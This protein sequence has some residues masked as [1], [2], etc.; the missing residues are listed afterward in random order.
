MN[1]CLGYLKLCEIDASLRRALARSINEP[2]GE[3]RASFRQVVELW[4][5]CDSPFENESGRVLVKFMSK[6]RIPNN[7]VLEWITQKSATAVYHKCS[8]ILLQYIADA[9]GEPQ[10]KEE[11]E[12]DRMEGV[13]EGSSLVVPR[14]GEDQI[15][16]DE[17]NQGHGEVL[18]Q[19]EPEPHFSCLGEF[20]IA[21]I[22]S[23]QAQLY[24]IFIPIL[25][26][27]TEASSSAHSLKIL[28]AHIPAYCKREIKHEFKDV[29]INQIKLLGLIAVKAKA[30]LQDP[31][32]A[33]GQ[34]FV[35]YL[36]ER[37]SA[38]LKEKFSVYVK[39]EVFNLLSLIADFPVAQ[40]GGHMRQ[41]KFQH[42]RIFDRLEPSL[43]YVKKMHFPMKS[44][45]LRP[46]SNEAQNFLVI[47]EAFLNMAIITRN[48]K[49]LRHLYQIIREHKTTF[50]QILKNSIN[51]I[52]TQQINTLPTAD[53]VSCVSEFISEFRDRNMDH[54]V[55]D[56][57]RWAIAR[58]IIV[59]ILETCSQEKLLEV[60]LHWNSDFLA[61]LKGTEFSDFVDQPLGLFNLVR[62][63]TFVMVFYEIMYRRLP[64]QV[65]KETVHRRIYGPDCAQNELSKLLIE[66]AAHA[67][68]EHIRGF[69]TYCRDIASEEP[70]AEPKDDVNSPKAVQTMY[71]CSAYSLLSSVIVCTQ[72]NEVVFA[73]FLFNPRQGK[74]TESLWSLIIDT[75]QEY[76]FKVQT[77]FN[78]IE[79]RSI[80]QKLADSEAA[81][82]D[83]A[84]IRI[85]SMMNE[86]L[87]SS[88]MGANEGF[89]QNMV[90]ETQLD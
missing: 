39:K 16:A 15:I 56:N 61:V 27:L 45:E 48:L 2:S 79:L 3:G 90:F 41:G 42:Q 35:Q 87:T 18:K 59:R 29:A 84:G 13:L 65:I 46:Q 64:A 12:P 80:E 6:L 28:V 20:L 68:R 22:P 66:V 76:E 58:K 75:T 32:N 4:L 30:L 73:N 11:P 74:A 77:N 57:I 33:E 60:M 53:F 62:E 25:E 54:S 34:V 10:E 44:R 7:V 82:Q 55:S 72:T 71:C 26:K 43:N 38:F 31:D 14:A 89:N 63:K 40:G 23:H 81:S 78:H 21:K 52:V 24:S 47:V 86:Y 19:S 17:E 5:N 49:V 67:K 70:P 50:E 37:I 1:L 69:E 8:D 88:F 83:I 9:W 51:I 85:Q 36:I